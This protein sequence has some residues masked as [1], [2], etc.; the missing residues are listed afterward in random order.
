[1][2]MLFVDMVQKKKKFV[3]YTKK[4]KVYRYPSRSKRDAKCEGTSDMEG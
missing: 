4:G 3:Y 1:M 2:Y